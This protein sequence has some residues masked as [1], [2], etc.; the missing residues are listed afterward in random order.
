M[1]TV[2]L[3]LLIPFVAPEVKGCPT[4]LIKNA[5]R[6][7]AI[8][9]CD[10]SEAWRYD[11]PATDITA[12]QADYTIPVLS[13]TQVVGIKTLFDSDDEITP[14]SENQLDLEWPKLNMTFGYNSNERYR[15]LP[16]RTETG[17]RAIFYYQKTQDT[18]TL[19]PIPDTTKTGGLTGT[20]AL[21]PTPTGT[22]IEQNLYN[23]FYEELAAGAKAQ[24]M[25]MPDKDWTNA[26]MVAYYKNLFDAGIAMASGKD[27]RSHQTTN[28]TVGRTRAYS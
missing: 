14:K 28:K 23:Q 10:K 6:S 12:T 17:A 26:N 15:A 11:I 13:E 18:V 8:R 4:A 22:L 20:I 24:L 7:A 27:A 16:W 5:I 19:V 1:A 2:S 25:A 9:F 21:K 3:D